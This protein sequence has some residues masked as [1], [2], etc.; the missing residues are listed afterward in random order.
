MS[1][2]Q[3]G[4]AMKHVCV[5]LFASGLLMSCQSV[6]P[7]AAPS[8]SV[9]PRSCSSAAA[10]QQ[11]S[12]TVRSFFAALAV[13]DDSAVRRLTTP[14]FYAFEVGKRFSGPELSKLIA[15]AHRSGRVL[16]WNIG[17]VDA[18]VDCSMAFAAWE[19]I[20]A[21]GTA[22]KMEP[23]AWL[24]SALLLRQGDGWVIDFLHSTPKDPRK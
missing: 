18:R 11:V 23:R 24:E 5:C 22:A 12:H 8:A 19:N 15:D 21:A 4:I 1:G 13:D 16:Q 10:A 2:Q 7:G 6:A 17:P 3:G 20:G 9:S 14:N